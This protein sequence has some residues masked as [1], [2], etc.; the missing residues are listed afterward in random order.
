MSDELRAQVASIDWYHTLE[1]ASGVVTP[2]WHDHRPIVGRLPLPGSLA[3]KRCLD[4]GTFNGFWAFEMERRGADEVVALD[5]L[6]PLRWDWPAGSSEATVRA[7]AGRMTQGRGFEIARGALG[8][9][10][11][12]LE[13]S[14]YDLSQ[15]EDGQFDFVFLGSL[16]VHLRDPVGALERVRSVCHS[17]GMLVV[18][19]G[20]D[21]GLTLR[22]PGI[23][24]ARLDGRGRPWWWYPNAC[25]LAR[26]VEVSGFAIETGPRRL[27]IPPGKGW[28]RPRLRPALLGSHEGRVALTLAC[29]GDPHATVLARPRPLD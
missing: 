3:G 23:P 7:L 9:S 25:G 20:I 18:M 2:G 1:L 17:H 16:I 6:D 5:V 10:V 22:H 4:I 14:V 28:T 29:L 21:L 27:F 19:D 12:R 13:R 8:S 24:A 15:D 11:R 26:I